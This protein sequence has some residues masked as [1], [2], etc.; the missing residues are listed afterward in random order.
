MKSAVRT[1]PEGTVA[2]TKPRRVDRE[3]TRRREVVMRPERIRPSLKTKNRK[4]AS[5][6]VTKTKTG[7]KTGGAAEP[8]KWYKYPLKKGTPGHL[9]SLYYVIYGS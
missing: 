2:R 3:I 9:H 5:L 1:K 7:I 4:P 6:K 8:V